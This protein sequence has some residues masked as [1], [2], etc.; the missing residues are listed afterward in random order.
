MG[1]DH[2]YR[3]FK[4]PNEIG[5]DVQLSRAVCKKIVD[6]EFDKCRSRM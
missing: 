3:R 4:T 1:S 5:M 2:T 6:G